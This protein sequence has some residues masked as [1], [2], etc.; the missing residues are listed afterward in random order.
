MVIGLYGRAIDEKHIP[1]V[2]ELLGLIKE[3]AI[4]LFLHPDY[5]K[6]LED[7]LEEKLDI[8]ALSSIEEL[9][10]RIDILFTLGGDGTILDTVRFLAG[11]TIPVFG[12]NTG[13]LGFLTSIG[14]QELA[15]GVAA[16]VNG[17]YHIEDRILLELESSSKL[18]GDSPLALNEFAVL[19][20]ESASMITVHTFIDKEYLN[21][22]W[23][24]GLIIATPTGSTGY[25]LSCGGPVVH[26]SS[27]SFVI[28]PIAPHNLT[29]RPLIISDDKTISFEIEGRDKLFLSSMDSRYASF[30]AS[31][32]L[33]VKKSKLSLKMVRLNDYSFLNNIRM[34]MMWGADQRNWE[35]SY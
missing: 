28:T 33:S 25:S 34:K 30:S 24:D 15:Q 29:V 12:I 17:Q 10:D 9:R 8:P 13:R 19:K 5:K 32:R 2:R 7:A 14:R 20:K 4:P 35:E 22:Y 6:V 11:S 3:Q 16:L 27:A 26:P 1:F 18:F 23:A 31:E 21:S